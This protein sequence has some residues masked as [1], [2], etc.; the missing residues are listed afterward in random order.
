MSLSNKSWLNF[1]NRNVIK[2][3]IAVLTKIQAGQIIRFNYTGDYAHVKRPLV[4][5]LNP[6]WRGKLHAV[7]LDYL[8]DD[9]LKKLY[10]IVKETIGEKIKKLLK[11]RLPLLKPDIADPEKFYYNRL[12]PFI[13]IN[14][15]IGESP[16]R[17][18]IRKNMTNIKLI[19][20][21]FKDMDLS[22]TAPASQEGIE[23]YD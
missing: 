3:H 15:D 17:T 2:E 13:K 22:S 6:N 14:F 7:T 20:Y 10:T 9:V 12:K 21:R 8:S 18:Y 19:D 4:L 11:L 5:V 16:Y 1:H 23:R